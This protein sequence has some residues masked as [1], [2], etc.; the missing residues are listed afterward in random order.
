MIVGLAVPYGRPSVPG[1]GRSFAAC[2]VIEPFAF[3]RAVETGRSLR[4]GRPIFACWGHRRRGRKRWRLGSTTDGRLRLWEDARGVWFAL[5]GIDLPAAFAGCSVQLEAIRWR[6][7]AALLW[8]LLEGG[9]RHI[10]ILESP[11]VP[12][13]NETFIE[14]V[15]ATLALP[16]REP[17]TTP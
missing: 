11:D 7:E 12:S 4:T 6:H 16:R 8:R 15:K 2:E 5:D 3:H 9:I 1:V 13:Y 17:E 10:A 14:T